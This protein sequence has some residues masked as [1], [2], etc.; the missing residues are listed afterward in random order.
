MVD[1]KS[2]GRA[3]ARFVRIS[4]YKVRKVI[5]LIKGKDVNSA[6]A[7]LANA[8]KRAAIF[9]ERALKSAIASAKQVGKTK[10]DELYISKITAD[11]GPMMKRYRA[12]AFGRAAMIRKRTSHISVELNRIQVQPKRRNSGP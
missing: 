11:D 6:L 4:P 12:A 3:K 2:A 8:D 9:L 7:I 10:Q 1:T 5:A